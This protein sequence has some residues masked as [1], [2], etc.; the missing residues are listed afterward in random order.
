MHENFPIFED[1]AKLDVT[2]DE[3]LYLEKRASTE[4]ADK[5]ID[6]NC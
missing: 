2:E 4:P 5:H 1:L 6:G 3:K